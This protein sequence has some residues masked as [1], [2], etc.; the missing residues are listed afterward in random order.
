MDVPEDI[1][2]DWDFNVINP[3]L[4]ERN[5]N[6]TTED[7][8]KELKKV[9]DELIVRLEAM[10]IEELMQPRRAD[11]PQK[12]PLVLWILGDTSEHFAE[13]RA[14]IQKALK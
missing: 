11:D 12:R 3:V 7:V 13:H 5:K 2:K 9:H 10:S 1:T 6:R 8:L 14:T 4:F